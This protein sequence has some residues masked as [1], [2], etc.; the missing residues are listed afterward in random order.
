MLKSDEKLILQRISGELIA[1]YDDEKTYCYNS[2]NMIVSN[3]NHLKYLLCLLNSK[4]INYYY[5]NEFSM[6][7]L[8]FNITQ[9][10]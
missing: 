8:T 10:D 5:V 3:N 2:V 7:A 4:L 1:S 9:G 6:N